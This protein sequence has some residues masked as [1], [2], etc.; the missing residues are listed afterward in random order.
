VRG[1]HVARANLGSTP[2]FVA[3][4]RVTVAEVLGLEPPGASARFSALLTN[5]EERI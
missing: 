3:A 4:L 1:S 5:M 2:G